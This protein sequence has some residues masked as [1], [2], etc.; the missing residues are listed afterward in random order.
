MGVSWKRNLKNQSCFLSSSEGLFS[1]IRG[2]EQNISLKWNGSTFLRSVLNF[3]MLFISG[4]S[5]PLHSLRISKSIFTLPPFVCP[6]W[7]CGIEADDRRITA[8]SQQTS[9][10][11]VLVATW[12]VF[13]TRRG[14]EVSAAAF[15]GSRK[16]K[17]K[18]WPFFGP[19]TDITPFIF[20]LTDSLLLS[21]FLHLVSDP[22]PP[23]SCLC[24]C[25]WNIF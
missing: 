6:Q 4:I 21:L 7:A 17:M 13:D 14:W 23:S 18:R 11:T 2:R 5:V 9:R 16:K 1:C 8:T 19:F 10:V 24:I 15:Y 3:A 25:T 22:T 20:S 12:F